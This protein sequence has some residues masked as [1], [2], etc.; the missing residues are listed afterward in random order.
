MMWR[1]SLLLLLLLLRRGAQGKPSPDAGPHGQG[2]VHQAAPLSE[3]PHDDAHGNFQYDHEAFLG[4]EVAKEFDQ[5]S[6]EESRAR[7]GRIVDRMDRA[8]DGDGWV[9]LAELRS[10]IAHTQQRHIRDSVSAAWNT[11]DTDRDGRVGWEEL[12]NATYGHYAPGE[13]FHDVEDAETYKKMLARDERRFR[14]ADQDGDSMATREELTAFLHPEEFPHMRDIVI[15]E[16]LEDLDKNKD[17]YVQVEEYIGPQKSS[18]REGDR[19]N[20]IPPPPGTHLTNDSSFLRCF[21]N[22]VPTPERRAVFPLRFA[23]FRPT[24]KTGSRAA[25]SCRDTASD[26][27]FI[28]YEG[29]PLSAAAIPGTEHLLGHLTQWGAR[30]RSLPGLPRGPELSR[31]P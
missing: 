30:P 14:V 4:R 20:T 24:E 23:H 29:L 7:L 6:P 11:Y 5:L 13:E 19:S 3:A 22:C 16:T 28:K 26:L 10:W 2:R 12:R 25:P 31:K 15:A 21:F 9:S 1:P 18:P 27:V 17:G 8:G